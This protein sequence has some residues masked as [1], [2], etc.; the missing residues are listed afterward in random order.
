MR[1]CERLVERARRR[2]RGGGGGDEEGDDGA[3]YTYDAH[4]HARMQLLLGPVQPL[5][6]RLEFVP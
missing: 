6:I 5:R 4:I 3:P 2:R 1:V